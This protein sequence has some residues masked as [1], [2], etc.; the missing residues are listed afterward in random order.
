MSDESRMITGV[1]VG[2][3]VG[4]VAAYLVFTQH[5]RRALDNLDATLEN[6]S[7]ALEKFRRALRRADGIVH[8]ARGAVE[9][10]RVMLKGQNLA[11][12]V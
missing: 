5:G 12:E 1:T 4:A 2:A 11:A 7:A 9:D 6:V 8:D 10:V 3:V